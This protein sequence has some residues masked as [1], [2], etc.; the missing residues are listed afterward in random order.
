MYNLHYSGS[1][2]LKIKNNMKCQL[3]SSIENSAT[4]W[5]KIAV[6]LLCQ[7]NSSYIFEYSL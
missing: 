1:A 7:K 5:M 6:E 3:F 2:E 4:N